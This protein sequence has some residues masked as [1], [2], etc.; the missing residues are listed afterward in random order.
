MNQPNW[1]A[2]LVDCVTLLVVGALLYAK[3]LSP[4]IGVPILVMVVSARAALSKPPGGPPS[5]GGGVSSSAVVAVA[6][7]LLAPILVSRRA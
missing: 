6:L 1:Q 5:A 7:G 3:V 2:V 4:E